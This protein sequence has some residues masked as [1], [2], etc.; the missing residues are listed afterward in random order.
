MK[1]E[2]QNV[3]KLATQDCTS[4]WAG[5]RGREVFKRGLVSDSSH[6]RNK[7]D[8]YLWDKSGTAARIGAHYVDNHDYKLRSA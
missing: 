6:Y 1:I 5:G 8:Y 4:P 2:L 3:L 7:Y